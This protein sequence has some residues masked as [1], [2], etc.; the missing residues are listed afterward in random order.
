MAIR[1]GGGGGGGAGGQGGGGRGEG[2]G[3]GGQL[4]RTQRDVAAKGVLL[5]SIRAQ[6]ANVQKT[7]RSAR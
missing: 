6:S 4:Q 2:G 7:N 5:R 3:A 1:G